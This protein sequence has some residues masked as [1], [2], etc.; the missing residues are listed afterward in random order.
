[1]NEKQLKALKEYLQLEIAATRKRADALAIKLNQL[2][3][4]LSYVETEESEQKEK[5]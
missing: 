5:Q 3:K 2:G 4:L 1:M